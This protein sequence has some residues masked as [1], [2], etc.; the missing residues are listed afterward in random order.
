[1]DDIPWTREISKVKGYDGYMYERVWINPVDAA[2]KG[3]RE[4]RHR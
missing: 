3:Y 4:R 1:M 2:L